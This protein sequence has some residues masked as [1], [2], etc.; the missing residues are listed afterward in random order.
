MPKGVFQRSLEHRRNISI[1]LTGRRMSQETRSKLSV[2]A[3]AR[4]LSGDTKAKI[5]DAVRGDKHPNWK[6]G[7]TYP[8]H[9]LRKTKEYRHWRDAVLERDGY[10]CTKCHKSKHRLDA[11]HVFSFT[12]FPEL[13]FDVNN[14][15]TVCVICHTKYKDKLNQ[16]VLI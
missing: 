11:H 12:L 16:L 3:S 2:I 1:A 15:V 13:R 9:A 10:R 6:G 5:G 4:T 8:I 7:V 14:G